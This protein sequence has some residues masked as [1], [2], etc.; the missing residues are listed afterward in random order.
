MKPYITALIDKMIVVIC[1][2]YCDFMLPV[3]KNLL[4]FLPVRWCKK[5]ENL[6]RRLCVV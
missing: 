3:C 2:I 6:W 5:I 1:C 4:R